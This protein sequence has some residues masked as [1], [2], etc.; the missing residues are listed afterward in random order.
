MARASS[1]HGYFRD[2]DLGESPVSSRSLSEWAHS[3]NAE[4]VIVVVTNY[5]ATYRWDLE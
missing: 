1:I 5:P 2:A 3:L 4:V